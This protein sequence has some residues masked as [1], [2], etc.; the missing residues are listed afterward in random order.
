MAEL[1]VVNNTQDRRFEV[2]LVRR[3]TDGSGVPG[4]VPT[5][6]ADSTVEG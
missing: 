3:R 1:E 2:N 5:M 6:V 4:V